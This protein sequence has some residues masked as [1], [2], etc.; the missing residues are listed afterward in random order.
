[1]SKMSKEED[2]AKNFEKLI[3]LYTNSPNILLGIAKFKN[4]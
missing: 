4:E 3:E 2:A 1:M